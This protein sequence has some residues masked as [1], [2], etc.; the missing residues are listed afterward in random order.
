MG[1]L[2]WWGILV[3]FVHSV[4]SSLDVCRLKSVYRIIES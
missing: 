2:Q 4:D 3:P 1:E